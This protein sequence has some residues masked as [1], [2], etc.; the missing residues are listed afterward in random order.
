MSTIDLQNTYFHISIH[1]AHHKSLCFAAGNS[2]Y[3]YTA[4]PFGLSASPQV[5]SKCMVVVAAH[6]RLQGVQIFQYID[7]WLLLA[8]SED[9]LVCHVSLEEVLHLCRSIVSTGAVCT[10]GHSVSLAMIAGSDVSCHCCGALRQM[11]H[12]SSTAMVLRV[13]NSVLDS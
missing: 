3:Q 2:H 12:A 11:A 4:F 9:V 6:L 7:N 13:F 8:S 5:F 10:A 1:P